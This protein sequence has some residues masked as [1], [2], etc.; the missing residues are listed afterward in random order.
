MA[1]HRLQMNMNALRQVGPVVSSCF[2]PASFAAIYL[3]SGLAG[4]LASFAFSAS[5]AVGASGAILG[6]FG[7]TW[8]SYKDNE[9]F[10][11]PHASAIS[12]SIYQS[13]ALT[14]GLGLVV[15]LIDNWCALTLH[16]ASQNC[17]S[18]VC[19]FQLSVRTGQVR[20]IMHAALSTSSTSLTSG[21]RH[22]GAILAE[23]C[24]ERG[25]LTFLGRACCPKGRACGKSMSISHASRWG[26]KF[27]C[28]VAAR[29]ADT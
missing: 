20:K 6:T 28:D 29:Q 26:C 19:C 14:L 15:P 4:S 17:S 27:D 23:C 2:K 16:T 7:A 1:L 22:P 25:W 13:I 3:L 11:G 12:T 21:A 24:V 18:S 5:P 9:A 8:M 10:L